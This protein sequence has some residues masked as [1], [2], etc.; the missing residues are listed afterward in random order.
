MTQLEKYFFCK[1]YLKTVKEVKFQ[2]QE[3]KFL[4][5]IWNTLFLSTEHIRIY[6]PA[7]VLKSS[8]PNLYTVQIV[9]TLKI[10]SIWSIQEGLNQK[11]RERLSRRI[12]G[13]NPCCASCLASVYLKQTIEFNRPPYRA[14]CFASICLKQTVE[15]NHEWLNSTICFNKTE[16][17]QLARQVFCPLIRREDL[18]LVF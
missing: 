12:G 1:I 18:C 8:H 11:T 7:L 3:C 14:S 4:N 13:Q 2:D 10:F 17:K 16:A 5:R 15:F 6:D 9:L